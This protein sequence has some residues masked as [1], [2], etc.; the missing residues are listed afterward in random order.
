MW[1]ELE[2][3][4]AAKKPLHSMVC[5]SGGFKIAYKTYGLSSV[6][7]LAAKKTI[8]FYNVF[9]WGFKIVYKIYGLS[10]WTPWLQ[11]TITFYIVFRW[12]VQN[13]L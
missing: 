1:F 7:T 12:R 3:T 9:R 13:S 6:D 11:K 5:S 8:P 4:L 2:D 10:S